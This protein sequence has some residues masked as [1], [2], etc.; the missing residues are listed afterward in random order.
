MATRFWG[1]SDCVTPNPPDMADQEAFSQRLGWEVSFSEFIGS[2]TCNVD[3]ALRPIYEEAN[4][5]LGREF[6]YPEKLK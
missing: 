2:G 4:Q 1:C 6:E 5:V 3:D